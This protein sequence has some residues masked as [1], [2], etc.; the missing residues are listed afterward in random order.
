MANKSYNKLR[1]QLIKFNFMRRST[2]FKCLMTAIL[3]GIIPNIYAATKEDG[4][5]LFADNFEYPAGELVSNGDW[6]EY[7]YFAGG[8]NDP[9]MVVEGGLSYA[10]YQ[11]AAVGNAVQ[12]NTNGV[13]ATAAFPGTDGVVYASFL[14]NIKA[15]SADGDFIF[16]FADKNNGSTEGYGKV[17]IK[18]VDGKLAFGVTRKSLSGDATYTEAT[19]KYNTTYLLVAK[20][21]QDGSSSKIELMVNPD[22]NKAEPTATVESMAGGQPS[23]QISGINLYQGRDK[24]NN[25]LI[26]AIRVSTTWGALFDNSQVVKIPEIVVPAYFNIGNFLAGSQPIQKTLNVKAKNLEQDIT[27]NYTS[28][29]YFSIPGKTISKADAE[30]KNG[31]DLVITLNPKDGTLQSDNLVFTSGKTAA[32][33][34]LSWW[35]SEPTPELVANDIATMKQATK[36]SYYTLVN[37]ITTTQI[38]VSDSYNQYT[39][40]DASGS[41]SV[42]DINGM[43]TDQV[44][45]GSELTNLRIFVQSEPETP[46]FTPIFNLTESPDLIINTPRSDFK[47]FNDNIDYPVGN[48]SGN[49]DWKEVIYQIDPEGTDPVSVVGKSLTYPGYQDVMAGNAIE[50]KAVG[51]E[52]TATFSEIDNTIYASMLVNIKAASAT[53]DFF[54]AFNPKS[55]G[56]YSGSGKVFVKQVDGKL[57]FGVSLSTPAEGATF[58]EAHYNFNTTYLL[59][60]KY[61]KLPEFDDDFVDLYINPEFTA[62]PENSLANNKE[63]FEGYGAFN[64]INVY[65]GDNTGNHLILDAIR[66][67]NSWEALF[68]D[69]KVVHLPE[70]TTYFVDEFGEYETQSF[71]LGTFTDE[72][73]TATYKVKAKNLKSNLT[74]TCGT[75]GYY[76]LNATTISKEAAE[77]ENGFDLV[78]TL[79]PKDANVIEDIITITGKQVNLET[80]VYWSY[81]IPTPEINA[82]NLA[83][84]KEANQETLYTLVNNVKLEEIKTVQDGMGYDQT[85][86]TLKD[87]S[88]ILDV[89]YFGE[90]GV[91]PLADTFSIEDIKKGDTF[92]NLIIRARNS[93]IDPDNFTAEYVIEAS[94]DL[95][96]VPAAINSPTNNVI[97]GYVNGIFTAE[98]ATNIRVYD[99]NGKQL[100]NINNESISLKEIIGTVL[101]IQYTDETG[102]LYTEKVI[103]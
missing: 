8:G 33:V 87:N 36:E 74:L 21:T 98:G 39:F 90:G 50:L 101:I 73:V 93:W 77:S 18:D 55:D 9:V 19:Y 69:S 100:S 83:R 76:T 11:S 103:K 24:G 89:Y 66:V 56:S 92:K 58:T 6:K 31:F 1:N 61:T 59:V 7:Q 4:V 63:G 65:Q 62:E 45:E 99:I 12:L 54:F 47:L 64:G 81:I 43:L 51:N 28:N 97:T 27:I 71:S 95:I 82:E 23:T 10:G 67:A 60:V 57:A 34:N 53:G 42:Y 37:P 102:N 49:G 78:I 30:S 72:P 29:G 75:E 20:Y 48:L 13:D 86:Y 2:I 80:P 88:G 22:I 14:V 3:L 15:A 41:F 17:H 94:P 5:K 84:L 40:E 25:A 70:V 52:A 96:I 79:N 38:S 16:S 32:T 44:K 85:V 35:Y 91:M 68:D 26:D 46:R